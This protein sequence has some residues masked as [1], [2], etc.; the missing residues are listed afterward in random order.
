MTTGAVVV[1]IAAT[2]LV[3]VIEEGD[4]SLAIVVS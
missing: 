3:N 1:Q 2:S 4:L